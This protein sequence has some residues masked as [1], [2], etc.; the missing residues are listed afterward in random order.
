MSI[1]CDGPATHIRMAELLGISTNPNDFTSAFYFKN[2]KIYFILDNCHTIKL[3]RNALF[4][5]GVLFD[6]DGQVSKFVINVSI[7][8]TIYTIFLGN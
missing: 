4:D 2:Q 5:L 6:R 7:F 1:T 8:I 3:M